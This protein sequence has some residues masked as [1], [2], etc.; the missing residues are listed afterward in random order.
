M[1]LNSTG[2]I[3]T[4]SVMAHPCFITIAPMRQYAPNPA[5]DSRNTEIG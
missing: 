2:P 1:R 5:S 4:T 3:K